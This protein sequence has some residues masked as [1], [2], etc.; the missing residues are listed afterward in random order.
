MDQY[1]NLYIFVNKFVFKI[2]KV[3]V[4]EMV[5]LLKEKFQVRLHRYINDIGPKNLF[6]VGQSKKKLFV[7][8][9]NYIHVI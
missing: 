4:E 7:F 3:I 9:M 1:I 2:Q 5:Y 6:S 8:G